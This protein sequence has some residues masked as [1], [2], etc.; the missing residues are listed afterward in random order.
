MSLLDGAYALI[1]PTTRAI[2]TIVPDCVI[3]EHHSDKLII[4]DHPVETGAAI[5]DHAFRMPSEVTMKIGFSNSTAKTEGW[6]QQAYQ[7]LLALM[8]QR[9]P[10]SVSTG[11]RLY[12]NMLIQGMEVV[13]DQTT[14][15]AL[16]CSVVLREIIIVSS[17]QS[18]GN[19]SIASNPSD[20]ASPE[21]TNPP[22][23]SGNVQLGSADGLPTFA[24]SQA[25]LSG[26]GSTGFSSISGGQGFQTTVSGF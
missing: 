9:Q 3:E 6:V 12:R 26:S 4:T 21:T 1:A 18:G 19:P 16:I 11:K 15:W 23:T 24:Q 10:F 17:S 20:Q 2:G 7:L 5:T 13:T 25:A 8:Q 22:V 14:E